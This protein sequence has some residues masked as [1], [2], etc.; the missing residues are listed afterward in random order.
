MRLADFGTPVRHLLDFP[1][2]DQPYSKA[3]LPLPS[4][5][6]EYQGSVIRGRP[7]AKSCNR[8][9]LF[10]GCISQVPLELVSNVTNAICLVKGNIL[11]RTSTKLASPFV[12]C[13]VCDGDGETWEAVNSLSYIGAKRQKDNF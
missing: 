3:R 5:P 6:V 11:N 1:R 9:E 13:R 2:C 12:R 7:L 10:F 4:H 8:T